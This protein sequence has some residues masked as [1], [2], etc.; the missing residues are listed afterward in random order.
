MT[1]HE[2]FLGRQYPALFV[3]RLQSVPCESQELSRVLHEAERCAL[4][5]LADD[6]ELSAH[7]HPSHP[8]SMS[9]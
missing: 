5:E 2:L 4:S 7:C 6:N 3:G 9:R 8:S 1:A